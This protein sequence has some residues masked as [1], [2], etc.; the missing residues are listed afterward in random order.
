[1]RKVLVIIL[2]LVCAISTFAQ[3]EPKFKFEDLSAE[4][5]GRKVPANA[6]KHYLGEEFTRMMFVLKE[7]YVQTPETST[8]NEDVSPIIRKPTI[9]TAV[10][11][12][13]IYYKKELR[14]G[15]IR[16]KEAK[17]RLMRVLNIVYS[18]RY[19][20][21]TNLEVLLSSIKGES[22]LEKFFRERIELKK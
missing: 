7:Q 10:N 6:R 21:T 11:H 15:R 12:I 22:E 3:T 9:Y 2:L 20:D 5:K 17:Q 8:L 1:M 13:D 18:I 4:L 16:K 14:K 19:V